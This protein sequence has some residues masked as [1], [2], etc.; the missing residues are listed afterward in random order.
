MQE[1]KHRGGESGALRRAAGV[2]GREACSGVKTGWGW[3]GPCFTG[4][5][6]FGEVAGGGEEEV[7]GQ[8]W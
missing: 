1:R 8:R 2:R 5:W 7:A 3:E 4:Q 6:R